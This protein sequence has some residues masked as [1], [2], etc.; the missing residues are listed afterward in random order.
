MPLS[1][2]AAD[3]AG[4]VYEASWTACCLAEVLAEEVKAIRL[5][6]PGIEGKG[7]EFWCTR[8][9]VKEFH[10]VKRQQAG[11]GRWTIRDLSTV[12]QHFRLHL[13]AA[14]N[15]I[16]FF[17]SSEG[18]SPLS[19][20]TDRARRATSA[21][22]FLKDFVTSS[23]ITAGFG[24]LCRLW[25]QCDRVEAWCLLRRIQVRTADSLT[26]ENLARSRIEPLVEGD[27]LAVADTLTHYALASF[28]KS[29]CAHD[30]WAHLGTRGYRATKW[31]NSA[32]AVNAV[33]DLTARYL[34]GEQSQI[35]QI[36]RTEADQVINA[37]ADVLAPQHLV[38][39]TGE[40]G[41]GKS[42]V[43]AQVVRLSQARGWP[44][45]AFRLDRVESHSRPEQLAPSLGLPGSPAVVLA[46]VAKGGD[47]LLVIDQLDTVST[48]S[49]RQ[50]Q[51][52]DCFRQ[53]LR[54]TAAHQHMR[55][56][57]CLS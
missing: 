7:V 5:E 6:P 47:S 34:A 14:Q 31:A 11:K 54:Q 27:P 26:L 49:G 44:T 21:E 46:A 50:P 48:V 52:F 37:L 35:V 38:L 28:N 1:G 13:V 23:E 8:A 2:G 45:L 12:L 40:A 24:E 18:A 57:N 56:S 55:I 22:E 16:C 32:T 43:A 33:Q 29:L 42:G 36:P 41:S 3:K 4:N 51:F 19:E 20:L 30:L 10:Q 39:L 53:L 17:V 25:G 15:S 9:G